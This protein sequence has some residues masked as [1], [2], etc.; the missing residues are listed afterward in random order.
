MASVKNYRIGKVK[1][2][3]T[4]TFDYWDETWHVHRPI[5]ED[6]EKLKEGWQ[7]SY[8]GVPMAEVNVDTKVKAVAYFKRQ[9]RKVFGDRARLMRRVEYL[10]V[11]NRELYNLPAET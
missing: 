4:S 10:L 1:P 9:C 2:N 8:K 6:G 3:Y 11:E 7:F 5:G